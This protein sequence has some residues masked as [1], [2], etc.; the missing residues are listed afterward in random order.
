M[1]CGDKTINDSQSDC[2]PATSIE[3]SR[4]N[5]N[6]KNVNY[7]MLIFCATRKACSYCLRD[8][9]EPL[10]EHDRKS[11]GRDAHCQF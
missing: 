2:E 9:G 8:L 1:R 7:L 3:R 10:E 11:R 5:K 4:L 6:A